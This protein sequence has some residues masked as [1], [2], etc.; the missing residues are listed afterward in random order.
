MKLPGLNEIRRWSPGASTRK[1]QVC[2]SSQA[3]VTEGWTGHNPQ[4]LDEDESV[5]LKHAL[6]VLRSWN[7]VFPSVD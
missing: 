7:F 6:T 2:A 5:T 4:Y 3:A 1:L